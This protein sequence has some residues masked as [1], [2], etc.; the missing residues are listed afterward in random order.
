[1]PLF[2]LFG[3]MIGLVIGFYELAKTLWAK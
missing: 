1:M 3:L 2:T